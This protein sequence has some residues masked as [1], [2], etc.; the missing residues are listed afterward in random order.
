MMDWL[1][2]TKL[3]KFLMAL[4]S[5]GGPSSTRTVVLSV[6]ATI[7]LVELALCAAA[8]TIAL[9]HGAR[10]TAD[11]DE[12]DSRAAAGLRHEHADDAV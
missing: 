10:R 7:C 8:C 6:N 2:N 4:L 12:R 1:A 3:L 5:D 9:R 11:G